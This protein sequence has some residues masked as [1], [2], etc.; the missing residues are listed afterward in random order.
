ML[1]P[2]LSGMG[3]VPTKVKEV[4][5]AAT[6]WKDG[7]TCTI[8]MQHLIL[9]RK[10]GF[11]VDHKSRDKLDNR[12][13]NLRYATRGQ[14]AANSKDRKGTSKFKGVCWHKRIGKWHAQ[15]TFRTNGIM[16]VKSLGYFTKEIDAAKAYQQAAIAW[17]GEFANCS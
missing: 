13:S 7:K 2:N 6:L 3:F 17:F 4:Y 1:F 5:A 12:W 15:I 11:I 10:T 8:L 9:P 14:N 16:R